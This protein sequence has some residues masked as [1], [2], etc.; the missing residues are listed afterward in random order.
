[1]GFSPSAIAMLDGRAAGLVTELTLTVYKLLGLLP[2]EEH[3][4]VLIH[5][6]LTLDT[7]WKT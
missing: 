5:T 2:R 1:M 6:Q 4:C 7:K 3:V